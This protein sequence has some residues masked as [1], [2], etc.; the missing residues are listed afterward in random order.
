VEALQHTGQFID[1]HRKESA[2]LLAQELGLETHSVERA[3]SRRSHQTRAMSFE[4]IKE[5]Q[6]IAD[7]FYALGLINKPVKVRD[8]VWQF[9]SALQLLA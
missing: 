9:S 4:V 1:N 3:L 5:Q 8:A 2:M 7:R 6:A